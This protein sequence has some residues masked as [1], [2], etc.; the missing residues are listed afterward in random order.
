MRLSTI[1]TVITSLV[2]GLSHAAC[3]PA[4]SAEPQRATSV[5]TGA[6]PR[7]PLI[8]AANEGERRIRRVM[9]GALAIIKVD[10][11]N[12]GS[13]DLMMGYEEVP[14]GQAI[15]AHRHASADEIV[16]VHR[17]SGTAELGDKTA[18]VGPGTTIFIPQATRVMLRNTGTEPLAVAYFFSHPGYEEYLR[19]TSVLDGQ[20][21]PPLSAEELSR[22]RERHT[23]H[24]AFDPQ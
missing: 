16:F 14:P 13:P 15:Q 17:G 11:Q 20:P 9:G 4:D 3:R 21:A 10:R 12:G 2:I 8:L 23:A 24:I 19:D 6:A 5:A 1:A 18:T 7:T 22:I